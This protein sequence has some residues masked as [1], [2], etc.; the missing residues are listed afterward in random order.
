MKAKLTAIAVLALLATGAAYAHDRDDGPRSSGAV[1]SN[2]TEISNDI[3]VQGYGLALGRIPFSSESSAVVDSTQS[4]S[5]NS[6]DLRRGD[7]KATVNDQALQ[8]A[9]GAV[10]LNVAAGAGNA[11]SNDVALAAVDAGKVFA[12][13]QVFNN[14][15][16]P[17]ESLAIGNAVNMASLSGNALKGAKGTI[18]VNIAAG[19]GNLQE[20]GMAASTNSSGHIA[21]AT[22]YNKQAADNN[23]LRLNG[24]DPTNVASLSGSALMNAMGNIGVNIA[25]GAGNLQHNGLAIATAKAAN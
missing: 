2:V 12:S 3:H 8:G 6:V 16:D 5:N 22:D 25:A 13:A 10:G 1:I 20:N 7:N 21:K 19:A 9:Q 14:Q 15:S 18:G 11:Q 23:S 17:G 24:C 4:S